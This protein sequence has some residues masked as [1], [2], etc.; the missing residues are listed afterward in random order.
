MLKMA[1]NDEHVELFIELV[2]A[3][4]CLYDL[5]HPDYKDTTTVKKNNWLDI[6]KEFSSIINDTVTGN[7][8][9]TTS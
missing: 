7:L 9:L 6:S 8:L 2:R 3:R 1:R 4:P 5:A